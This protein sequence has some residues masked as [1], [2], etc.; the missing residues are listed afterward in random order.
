[1]KKVQARHYH[2]GR[3]S[4]VRLIVCHDMEWAE[5]ATTAEDCARMFATMSRQASAHVCVDNDT[6]VR[7]VDDADTA[8]AA[9]GA[10]SDGLQLEL[11]GFMKQTREQWLD[12]YGKAMF[13]IAAKVCAAWCAKYKIPVRKLTQAE[14]RA[15]KKGFT[16]HAD[17]SAVYRRTDHTD[18]GKGFPWD[19]FLGLVEDVL[20]GDDDKEKPDPARNDKPQVP[21][22]PG[23]YLKL[24]SRGEDVKTWQ[25]QMRARGWSIKV[26][27]IFGPE[28][29]GACIVFQEE[30]DLAVD[31]VVGPQT[32]TAAWTEPIE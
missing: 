29:R 23:R 31:G 5:R 26:D 4:P 7:C 8:W 32:W 2:K 18:P 3:I 9:P 20:E 24:G 13:A 12:S 22:W 28:T 17:V 25:R 11:A 15:G 1:M 14:L 27:G 10:N 16:S 30:H 6:A 21:A 19:Y